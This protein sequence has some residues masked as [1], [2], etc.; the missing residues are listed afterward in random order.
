MGN[1]SVDQRSKLSLGL[2]L[3]VKDV[4]RYIQ[5]LNHFELFSVAIKLFIFELDVLFLPVLLSSILSFQRKVDLKEK[6]LKLV[7]VY[8]KN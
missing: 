2:E 6:C 4:M 3:G 8:L 7:T 1:T 5:D